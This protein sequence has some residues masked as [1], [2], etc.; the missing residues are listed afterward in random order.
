MDG[1]VTTDWKSFGGFEDAVKANFSHQ[2]AFIP[3]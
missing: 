3:S 2:G 1:S